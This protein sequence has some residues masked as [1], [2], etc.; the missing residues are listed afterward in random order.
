MTEPTPHVLLAT[1]V[2]GGVISHQYLHSVLKIQRHFDSLGWSLEVVTQPDG[3][4]TRSRNS[5]A[6]VVVRNEKF[7]HLLMLDADVTVEPEGIER[8]IR[9]GHDFVGC[10]VPFREVDWDKVRSHL[11]MIP[12]A[13]AQHLKTMS[14]KYA[15][16]PESKQKSVNGFIPVHAIGSAIMLLSRSALMKISESDLVSYATEGLHAS[17][18]H[19]EGWTFFDPFVDAQGVYL[20]EDYALCQRWRTLGGT[21]W[22][23]LRTPTHHIGPVHIEGN[24]EA[25]LN[26]ASE[27]TRAARSKKSSD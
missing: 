4:V 3:L 14:T 8:V 17:D 24:I 12:D 9:S 20:S 1:P 18:G 23:D 2:A 26:A 15:L 19:K 11:D 16:W 5:F 22:A 13:S 25:S 27:Y 6:S 21:V 7:T 10:V